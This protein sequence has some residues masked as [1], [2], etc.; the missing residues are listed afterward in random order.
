MTNKL[1]NH[2]SPKSDH[3]LDAF[4][5][6]AGDSFR[7]QADARPI[8]ALDFQRLAAAAGAARA[9]RGRSTRDRLLA[10]L[11]DTPAARWATA[12]GAA[13]ILA[14]GGWGAYAFFGPAERVGSVTFLSSGR[15]TELGDSLFEG[16]SIEV[17][18]GERAVI[19]A[20]GGRFY[21]SANA[22]AVFTSPRR[23]SIFGGDIWI[24]SEGFDLPFT[25]V[26]GGSEI[27]VEA[28]SIGLG[29]DGDT[30]TVSVAKGEANLLSPKLARRMRAGEMA[31]HAVD[32]NELLFDRSGVAVPRWARP[33]SSV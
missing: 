21:L 26:A 2:A 8:P 4:L 27:V 32:S 29:L 13:A 12:L 3:A 11:G 18:E 19:E 6:R 7:A 14:T 16:Q 9:A 31:R 5:R 25:V 28:G 20:A 33:S 1:A 30:L 23:L 15:A 24:E 10:W 22:R 17:G